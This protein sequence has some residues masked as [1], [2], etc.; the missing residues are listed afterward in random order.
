M[1]IWLFVDCKYFVVVVVFFVVV[2]VVVVLHQFLLV[3][4][5]DTCC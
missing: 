4:L 3:Q 2:V 1:F 5:A